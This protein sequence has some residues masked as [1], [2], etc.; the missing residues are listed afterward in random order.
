MHEFPFL[1]LSRLLSNHTYIIVSTESNSN[2]HQIIRK[3]PHYALELQLL[4]S[5]QRSVYIDMFFHSFNKVSS[6]NR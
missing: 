6:T 4:T 5:D 2:L 3:H 1:W